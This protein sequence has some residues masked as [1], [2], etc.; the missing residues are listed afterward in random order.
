[1]K[2]THECD[3]QERML[4]ALLVI[5]G[6]CLQSDYLFDFPTD[7]TKYGPQ[8]QFASD[9]YCI[10]H[11][12]Q[13]LCSDHYGWLNRIDERIKNL[14]EANTIDVEEVVAEWR[15]GLRPH[16]KINLGILKT[17]ANCTPS[18][19]KTWIEAE[20]RKRLENLRERIEQGAK[21]LKE[22][23][24]EFRAIAPDADLNFA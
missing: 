17:K 3:A 11:A 10:S 8:A 21:Q 1:M 5:D 7:G 18:E 19:L 6:I 16:A 24:L 9:M 22:D 4:R 15:A 13:G 23:V 14:K 2:P 12:G 20:E